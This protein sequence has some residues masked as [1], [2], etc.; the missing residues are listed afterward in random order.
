MAAQRAAVRSFH[1]PGFSLNCLC[2]VAVHCGSESQLAR[3]FRSPEI[4][5]SRWEK[6]IVAGAAMLVGEDPLTMLM[7]EANATTGILVGAQKELDVLESL[8]RQA[9]NL[10]VEMQV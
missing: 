2:S 7:M 3:N 9:W 1:G 4:T 6:S 8:E 5:D 10:G